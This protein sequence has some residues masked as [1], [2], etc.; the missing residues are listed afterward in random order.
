MGLLARGRR[1][2]I[3]LSVDFAGGMW[4][5][6]GGVS[7]GCSDRLYPGS[8]KVSGSRH[9]NICLSDDGIET[10]LA[11]VSVAEGSVC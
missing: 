4:T 3:T 9:S 11:S 7:Q 10:W 2:G 6:L 5:L 8:W 1:H